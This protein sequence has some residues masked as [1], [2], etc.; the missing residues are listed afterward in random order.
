MRTCVC[1]WLLLSFFS[2]TK[3]L[4]RRRRRRGPIWLSVRLHLMQKRSVVI[5]KPQ[6]TE[7]YCFKLSYFMN[8][9]IHN[10]FILPKCIQ[11]TCLDVTSC[12]LRCTTTTWWQKAS[13]STTTRNERTRGGCFSG[14]SRHTALSTTRLFSCRCGIDRSSGDSHRPGENQLDVTG[15]GRFSLFI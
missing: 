7:S 4:A 8:T 2:V 14:H 9:D 15:V 12:A 13:K 11:L 3:K 1:V 5:C 10:L 6:S